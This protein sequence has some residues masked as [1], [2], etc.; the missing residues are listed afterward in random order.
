MTEAAVFSLTAAVQEMANRTGRVITLELDDQAASMC[1]AKPNQMARTMTVEDI[2]AAI[3]HHA[4]RAV[5]S[6][7]LPEHRQ[8]FVEQ[9]MFD[10]TRDVGRLGERSLTIQVDSRAM[11]AGERELAG[12]PNAIPSE[13]GLESMWS[14]DG[15]GEHPGFPRS[16]WREAVA[17]DDTIQGYW[18]WLRHELC[19][20]ADLKTG[21]G[22]RIY[23]V[24]AMSSDKQPEFVNYGP[25]SSVE[26]KA[27][28][29][30]GVAANGDLI[31]LAMMDE[32]VWIEEPSGK[33]WDKMTVHNREGKNHG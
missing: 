18:G 28:Y 12:N 6:C 5:I 25:F 26:F 22:S 20:E 31:D 10:A 15:D 19:K 4:P 21:D 30:V 13:A 2:N 32:G 3:K 8:A 11:S 7:M 17:N 14:P 27:N 1:V 9:F 29:M 23:V 24:F 33:A 16:D